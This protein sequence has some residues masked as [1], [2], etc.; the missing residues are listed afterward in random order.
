MMDNVLHLN[1][2]GLPR[3]AR[4]AIIDF[5]EFVRHKY[6]ESDQ[7]PSKSRQKTIEIMEKGAYN[8]PKD[9]TFNRDELYD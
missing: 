4:Q 6:R 5:Y 3:K 2:E 7:K 9:F 8:L 1:I